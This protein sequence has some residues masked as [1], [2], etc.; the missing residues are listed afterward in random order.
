MLIKTGLDV[1]DVGRNYGFSVSMVIDNVSL[2]AEVRRHDYDRYL[3]AL[4]APRD[5]R[6]D[7]IALFAFNLELARLRERVSAPILGQ[8][9]LTWWHETIEGVFD[10]R[11]RQ[12]PIAQSL[13]RLVSD[14]GLTRRM[15]EEMIHSRIKE[16]DENGF[17]NIHELESFAEQTSGALHQIGLEILGVEQPE[18]IQAARHVGLAWALVG[19]C[20]SVPYHA[21]RRRLYLPQDLLA[22]ENLS[23]NSVMSMTDGMRL[24][25]IIAAIDTLAMEHLT[26]AR[27]LKPH[28]P[29]R[30][31]PVLLPAILAAR[32]S[33]D[34]RRWDCNPFALQEETTPILRQL[35]LIWASWRKSY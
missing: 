33:C 22:S 26:A 35:R 15:I 18:A 30:A 7:L 2:S 5:R 12:H 1:D 11:P 28:V 8:I 9:R 29:Q 19:F 14:Y 16:F 21:R 34:L 27:L 25:P 24:R 3:C 31:L 13:A 10:G 4:F 23:P 32:Y 6:T 20:R 17:A